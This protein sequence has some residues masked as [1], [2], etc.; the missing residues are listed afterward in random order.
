MYC[1][2]S[3]YPKVSCIFGN[4]FFHIEWI[5]FIL[6][7]FCEND[8]RFLRPDHCYGDIIYSEMEQTNRNIIN[9]LRMDEIDLLLNR[10]VRRNCCN[11]FGKLISL[12][13]YNNT[14]IILCF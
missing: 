4:D 3:L 5:L 1:T 2:L 6:R 7:G 9:N 14:G 8:S 12:L 10:N 11:L 13:S